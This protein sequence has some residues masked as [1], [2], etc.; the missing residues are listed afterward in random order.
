MSLLPKAW[1]SIREREASG[2]ACRLSS[3]N[4]DLRQADGA[5]CSGTSSSPASISLAYLDEGVI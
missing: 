2:A 5:P 3:L 1:V 4:A